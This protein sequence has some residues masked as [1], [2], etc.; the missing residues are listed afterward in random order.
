MS[1]IIYQSRGRNIL[2]HFKLQPKNHCEN[3]EFQLAELHTSVLFSSYIVAY[4][5]YRYVLVD[6]NF[7]SFEVRYE[8]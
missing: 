6:S 5:V 8:V 2:E 3:I 1:V 7:L 4:V